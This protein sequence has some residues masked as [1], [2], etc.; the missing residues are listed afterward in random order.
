MPVS[1]RKGKSYGGKTYWDLYSRKFVSF[2]PPEEPG[3]GAW[4]ILACDEE[5]QRVIAVNLSSAAILEIARE[6]R[7]ALREE[8]AS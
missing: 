6:V 4:S 5:Q 7:A 1:D 8:P 3:D 2:C